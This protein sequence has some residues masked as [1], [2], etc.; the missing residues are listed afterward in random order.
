MHDTG[1]VPIL[2]RIDRSM[3]GTH[4]HYVPWVQSEPCTRVHEDPSR[5][6]LPTAIYSNYLFRS[7]ITKLLGALHGWP[8]PRY[9]SAPVAIKRIKYY[10][11]RYGQY[12]SFF[13]GTRQMRSTRQI[14]GTK[15]LE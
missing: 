7:N 15:L 2:G 14:L 4:R 6:R 10:G 3:T 11:T 13:P 5:E 8:L 1:T 12:S 9:L